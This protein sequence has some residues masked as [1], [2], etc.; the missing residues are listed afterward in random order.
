MFSLALSQWTARA[1]SLSLS[2][3]LSISVFL[4][5]MHIFTGLFPYTPKRCLSL[6]LIHPSAARGVVLG[7]EPTPGE[8]SSA[9]L[10]DLPF[11]PLLC[12]TAG[13]QAF[14]L[15]RSSLNLREKIYPISHRYIP[16][17]R[18]EQHSS[19]IQTNMLLFI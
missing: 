19:G 10:M 18:L 17:S 13:A 11:Q 16:L 15:S 1:R 8:T 6:S 7:S 4:L 3:S 5:H 14:T 9:A 12:P 2:L